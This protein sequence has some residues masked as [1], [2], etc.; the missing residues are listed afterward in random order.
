MS[1]DLIDS[2][3]DEE[4]EPLNPFDWGQRRM[5]IVQNQRRRRNKF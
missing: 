2:N 3:D 5:N 1:K 4:R